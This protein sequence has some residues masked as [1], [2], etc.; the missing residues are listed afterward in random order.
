MNSTIRSSITLE[1]SRGFWVCSVCKREGVLS[2]VLLTREE[3]IDHMKL[4]HPIE[5]QAYLEGRYSLSDS[6]SPGD[7]L[8]QA[9]SSSAREKVK[10]SSQPKPEPD[11]T[12]LPDHITPGELMTGMTRLGKDLATVLADRERIKD[13]ISNTSLSSDSDLLQEVKRKIRSRYSTIEL[14]E[15]LSRYRGKNSLDPV[16]KLLIGIVRDLVGDYNG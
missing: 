11:D 5:Y 2:P 16:D 4:N 9:L 10:A 15:V 7:L 8:V 12:W 13:L 1:A 6:V 3:L 14:K